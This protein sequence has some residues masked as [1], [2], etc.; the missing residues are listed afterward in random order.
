MTFPT[1]CKFL[2][3]DS[4]LSKAM[5]KEGNVA[6]ALQSIEM[7]GVNGSLEFYRDSKW[8]AVQDLSPSNAL[9]LGPSN[10]LR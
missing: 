5:F 3:L 9:V 2:P 4:N 7:H 8:T 6:V 10:Y 1:V